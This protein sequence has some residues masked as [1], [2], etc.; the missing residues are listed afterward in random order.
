MF[1]SSS[2]ISF[3]QLKPIPYLTFTLPSEPP[4]PL[5][6][7]GTLKLYK[8][9]TLIKTWKACSGISNDPDDYNIKDYGPIPPGQWRL[10]ERERL[11]S[12]GRPGYHLTP[13][14]VPDAENRYKNSFWIHGDDDSITLGCIGLY[15][16]STANPPFSD[17]DYKDFSDTI[18]NDPDILQAI[19]NYYFYLYVEYGG[20]SGTNAT[21]VGGIIVPVDKFALLAPYIGLTSTVIVAA[22]VS[23]VYVKHVKHRKEKQ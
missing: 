16:S 15:A 9:S 20:T 5:W 19:D 11:M 14:W 18:K 8:G 17:G 4:Q 10:Q 22:V 12:D 13:Y 6:F 3:A 1:L 7:P 2:L 23:V 21:G